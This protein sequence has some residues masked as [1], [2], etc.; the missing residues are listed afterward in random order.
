MGRGKNL[1]RLRD[2]DAETLAEVI[3]EGE[4]RIEAQ[5]SAA[6]A[7]DQR[8]LSWAGFV[9]TITM[10]TT[11]G[12]ITLI[13]SNILLPLAIIGVLL[14]SLLAISAFLA[15]GTV[16]PKKFSLPGNLP[17]NWLPDEWERGFGH[18]LAQARIEQAR[19]LNDQI[20]DNAKWAGETAKQLSE[21]MALALTAVMVAA[22]YSFGFMIFTVLTT[23]H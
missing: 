7:A 9:V 13:S 18:N 5:F 14:S 11:A 10:A 17:E 21:S 23:H 2:L 3:R 4:A 20:D 8:A 6:T 12:S 15:V 19:C 22:L 1:N 16:L